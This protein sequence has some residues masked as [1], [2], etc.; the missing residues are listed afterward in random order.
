MLDSTDPPSIIQAKRKLADRFRQVRVE[1]F[2]LRGDSRL[3]RELNIPLRTWLNYESGVT[4][5]GEILLLFLVLTDVEPRWLL[6]GEG[7][8]YRSAAAG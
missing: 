3:A 7:A 5:P 8:M 1:Q 4:I 6:S 2:G